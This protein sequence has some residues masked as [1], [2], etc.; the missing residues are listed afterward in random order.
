MSPR[1]LATALLL[2][3][4][5]LPALLAADK[6][7]TTLTIAVMD[8]AKDRPVPKASVTLSFV[9]GRKMVTRRKI[10]KEWN[11]KTNSRGIAELPEIP[12]GKVS[13][14]VIA[15]GFQTY[16]DHFEISGEAQTVTVKL[17]RPPGGQV[18]AHEVAEPVPEKKKPE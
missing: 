16:G 5:L 15:A 6:D 9:S 3:L 4:C 12:A 8:E 14:Q 13:L 18:S 2:L 10:R 17:K 7:Y 11:T 1:I